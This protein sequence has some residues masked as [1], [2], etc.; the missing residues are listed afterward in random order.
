MVGDHA[1]ILICP[2]GF[3]KDVYEERRKEK[4]IEVKYCSNDFY[5]ILAVFLYF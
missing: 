3:L 5:L 4:K 1:N 2:T